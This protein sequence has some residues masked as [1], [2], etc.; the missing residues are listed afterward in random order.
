MRLESNNNNNDSSS[1]S[2]PPSSPAL[3]SSISDNND[4][5]SRN[6]NDKLI[7]QEQVKALEQPTVKVQ[8]QVTSATINSVASVFNFIEQSV[9]SRFH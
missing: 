8:K 7:L 2:E 1:E 4:M 9:Q 3:K 6:N 5:A